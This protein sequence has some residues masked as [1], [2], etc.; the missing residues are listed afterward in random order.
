[1]PVIG[2]AVRGTVSVATAIKDLGRFRQIASIL[3]KHGLGMALQNIQVPG[4]VA[5]ARPNADGLPLGQ[6][7]VDAA[8]ELGPTFVKLGQFLS[9]RPDLVPRHIAE[10]LEVLQDKVSQESAE[11]VRA[12]VERCLGDPLERHYSS[13]RDEPIAAASV[14]QVHEATTVEG[15][16]VAVKV[17]RPG[18]RQL[19]VTDL[20]ILAFLARQLESNFEELQFLDLQNTVREFRRALLQETDLSNELRYIQRFR[21]NFAKRPEIVIPEPH[22]R[23]CGTTVLTMDFL[24]GT[25]VRTVAA[26]GRDMEAIGRVF[27]DA[28][29]KMLFE[30]GFFHAD[31]HP[32]NVLVLDG[33]RLGLLD[34][35]MTGSLT[36]DVRDNLISLMFAVW[37][38]DVRAVARAF[39]D[40][41]IHLAPV[42]YP[43]FERD[44]QRLLEDVVGGRTLAEIHFGEVISTVLEGAVEHRMRVPP[45]YLMFFK[46][47]MSAEGLARA[48]APS[49]NPVEE[50]APYVEQLFRDRYSGDQLR[51]EALGFAMGMRSVLRALPGILGQVTREYS[52][53]RFRVPVVVERPELELAAYRKEQRRMR[54]AVLAAAALVGTAIVVPDAAAARWTAFLPAMIF[55]STALLLARGVILGTDR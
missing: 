2:K 24:D 42:S 41:G 16:R 6:R 25:P 40:I 26:T 4:F 21:A 10:S 19:V 43:A 48:I 28:S 47:I 46:G 44:V 45:G 38:N 11:A 1:M 50:A 23:H 17:L 7:M 22:P 8:Q 20:S 32:G 14:A 12:E 53:G 18:V 39:W 3:V 29:F 34:F 9:T 5:R 35:G 33:D 15:R 51:E 31:L 37:R 30:D 54:R 55:G 52:E 49:V 13:F 36:P 27:L